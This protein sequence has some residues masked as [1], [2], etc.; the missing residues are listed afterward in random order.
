[1]IEGLPRLT[2]QFDSTEI[3]ASTDFSH[4]HANVSRSHADL[5]RLGECTVAGYFGGLRFSLKASLD[6]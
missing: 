2:L 3:R 1:M 5:I 4:R 6:E